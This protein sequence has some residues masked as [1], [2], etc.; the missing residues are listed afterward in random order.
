MSIDT[1]NELLKKLHDRQLLI[2][3]EI[4]RICK[5][6]HLTYYLIG[7]S[8]LGA[9]RHHGFI[10]WDD[11]IDLGMFRDD[12]EKFQKICLAGELNKR[13]FLQNYKTDKAYPYF[14]AKIRLNNT[15]FL[16]DDIKQIKMHHG[17][18]ID[19]FP[20]D[21][22]PEHKLIKAFHKLYFNTVNPLVILSK[23]GIMSEKVSKRLFQKLMLSLHII[24]SN[25]LMKLTDHIC[26]STY[27]KSGVYFSNL[28]GRAGYDREIFPK[29]YFDHPVYMPFEDRK[30]PVPS[31]C[32]SYMTQIYG[33]YMTPPPP[34]KRISGH[35]MCIIDFDRDYS[36]FIQPISYSKEYR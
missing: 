29:S 31:G 17:I 2:I 3:D 30:L 24:Q 36:E 1:E 33:D 6:N 9:I 16:Q 26:K 18:F 25:I 14:F 22:I 34:E 13:F 19:I 21:S 32:R 7:G 4:G 23:S 28:F 12:Y 20:L 27:R 10:P 11:D 5:N 8:A 35:G 15:T